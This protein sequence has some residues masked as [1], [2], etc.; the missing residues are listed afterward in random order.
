MEAAWRIVELPLHGIRPN[1]YRLAVHTKNQQSIIFEEG[2]EENAVNY[3]NHD[4]TLT[5][6]FDLNKKDINAKKVLY[7]NIPQYY[8]FDDSK[9]WIKRKN[10]FNAVGRIINVS[11][12][13]S[14]R[15]HLKLLLN[16]VKEAISFEDLRTYNGIIYETFKETA[17]ELG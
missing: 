8:F 16:R 17:I 12:K 10:H 9:K 1:V 13:D 6:W 11:L 7:C 15:F 4:T 3:K 2:K 5:A 14:E